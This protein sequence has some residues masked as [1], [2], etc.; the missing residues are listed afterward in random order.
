MGREEIV[1]S[2]LADERSLKWTGGKP[3]ADI[4][5]VPGRIVNVV[6]K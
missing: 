1:N 4:I 2:V 5:V 3:P 6:V